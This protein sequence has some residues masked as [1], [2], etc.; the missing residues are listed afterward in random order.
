[1]QQPALYFYLT[2]LTFVTIFLVRR[3]RRLLWAFVPVVMLFVINFLF[4]PIAYFRY[5]MPIAFVTPVI[6]AL[7]LQELYYAFSHI[8]KKKSKT[9]I[10]YGTFDTLHWGHIEIF[11]RAKELAGKEGKLL[12]GV[13][14]DDFN[15]KKGKKSYHNYQ[16]RKKFV[17]SIR[18]VDKTFPET[19]WE[20]KAED[21][22]KYRAD[23]LVMGDDWRN[24]PEFEQVKDLIETKFLPRTKAISST[25]IR[26]VMV[27]DDLEEKLK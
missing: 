22:K 26:N 24:A 4:G 5:V 23:I 14:T 21:F 27:V 1:M 3:S 7:A 11:R 10:T 19:S 6:V 13:S 25:K 20:Q 16:Q 8:N 15:R 12:V 2:I 18:Y 9:V 17:E